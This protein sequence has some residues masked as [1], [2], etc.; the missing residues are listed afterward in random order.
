MDRFILTTAFYL[1]VPKTGL[2]SNKVKHCQCHIQ[3]CFICLNECIKGI[4]VE[5][6]LVMPDMAVA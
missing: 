2:M 5:L 3:S 6:M 1:G 4:C